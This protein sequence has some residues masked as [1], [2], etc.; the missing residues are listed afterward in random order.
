ME[1]TPI[2]KSPPPLAL[3]TVS[4]A[5]EPFKKL[6]LPVAIPKNALFSVSE[7]PVSTLNLICGVDAFKTLY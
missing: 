6:L 3:K 2:N 7:S 4:F 1:P 5:T